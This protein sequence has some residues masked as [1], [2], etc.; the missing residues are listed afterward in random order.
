MKRFV[1]HKNIERYRE[2]LASET[3]RAARCVLEQLLAE[4]QVK[5]VTLTEEASKQRNFSNS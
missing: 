1:A 4:E 3:D 2:L 5:L